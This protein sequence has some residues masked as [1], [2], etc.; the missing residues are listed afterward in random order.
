VRLG[1]KTSL[2]Y[3]SCSGETGTDSRKSAPE[4]VTQVM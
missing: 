3:F 1:H 4:N 2:H